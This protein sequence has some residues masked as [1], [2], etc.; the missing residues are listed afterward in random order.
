MIS[1]FRPT[2]AQREDHHRSLPVPMRQLIV[3]LKAEFPAFTLGEIASICAIQFKGRRPSKHTVKAVLADGPRPSHTTR[4]FPRAEEITDPEERH[5]AVIHLHAASVECFDHCSLPGR[6]PPDDLCHPE[7]ALVEEGVRGLPDKSHANT[8]KLGVDLPTRNL[9]RK[10][11][12]ENPLLGEYR[13]FAAL[14]QLGITVPPR[15][16]G[17]IMRQI[18]SYMA[19]AFSRRSRTSPNR[20]RFMRQLGTSGGV[21]IFAIWKN[22]GFPTSKARFMSSR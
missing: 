9:I 21:W 18:G 12:E 14:K 16:C 13:M 22:I 8:S 5:L 10:K 17:R 19:C 2:K 3:D 11:Q 7:T 15:T 4:Q 1:L 20:T 6:V